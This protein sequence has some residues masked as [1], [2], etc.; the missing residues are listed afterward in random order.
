MAAKEFNYREDKIKQLIKLNQD[1]EN[2]VL[3]DFHCQ[4]DLERDEE[5]RDEDLLEE[6][7]VE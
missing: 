3:D 6:I 2:D 5:E 4:E 1:D 7:I